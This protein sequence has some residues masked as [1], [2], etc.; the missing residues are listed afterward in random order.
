MRSEGPTPYLG[1]DIHVVVKNQNT[2][3]LLKINRKTK[4]Q[5][6]LDDNEQKEVSL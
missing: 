1:N 5:F 6:V 3:F 2:I 4:I